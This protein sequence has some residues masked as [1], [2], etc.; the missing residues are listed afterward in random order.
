M[1]C[2]CVRCLMCF[3]DLWL[4][5]DTECPRFYSAGNSSFFISLFLL[6]YAKVEMVM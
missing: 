2:K 6:C 1:L 5:Y 4:A 3:Y